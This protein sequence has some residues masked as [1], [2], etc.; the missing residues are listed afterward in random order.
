MEYLVNRYDCSRK[1]MVITNMGCNLDC[2]YCY[3]R[4]KEKQS[5]FDLDE[6]V[7]KLSQVLKTK[8]SKG[9]LIKLLG[10]EPFLVFPNIKK[11]CESIWKQKQ[12]DNVLFHAT[13]NGTLIHG[14]IKDWLLANRHRFTIKLSLDGNKK[15]HDINRSESFD[16]IDIDFFKKAWPDVGIK[17]TISPQSIRYFADSVMFLHQTGFKNIKPNFAEFVD[18][19]QKDLI[20]AFYRQMMLLV[21]FYLE[22]PQ[23]TPCRY[24][25]IPL[26]RIMED[27]IVF[28]NC[29]LGE[30]EIYD[31]KT[32][33]HYPCMFFLPSICGERMS[34]EMMH[35][36]MSKQENLVEGT[37][38]NCVFQNVCQTCY[39]ANYMQRGGSAR[40]NM[41]ICKMQQITFLATS[42]LLYQKYIVKGQY[43]PNTQ[44][45]VEI[46]KDIEAISNITEKLKK[47][48]AEYESE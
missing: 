41:N 19:T 1:I 46:Y 4:Q 23:F 16:K 44:Y 22:N 42:K 36:D 18:W 12:I 33:K 21:D 7:D 14:Y 8:T 11:L 47:I 2:I 39:A 25:T 6:T 37:C 35:L 10:G 31:Y 5:V 34:E 30:R 27:K 29:T 48:E 45:G 32:G 38:I 20:I 26:R 15:A 13:S 28:H 40:R 3:E 43:I 24:F 9:T 17:M